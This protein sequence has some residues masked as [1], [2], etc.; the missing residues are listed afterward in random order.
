MTMTSASPSFI[1]LA[2]LNI[3]NAICPTIVAIELLQSPLPLENR[4]GIFVG[5]ASAGMFG[6]A[7]CLLIRPKRALVVAWVAVLLVVL[8]AAMLLPLA[9]SDTQS[10][11]GGMLVF[12]GVIGTG[13]FALVPVGTLFWLLA[14]HHSGSS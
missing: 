13:V 12:F 14:R 1:V 8:H 3:L 4:W 5:L 6:L 11:G 2:A 9:Y 10:M 7:V